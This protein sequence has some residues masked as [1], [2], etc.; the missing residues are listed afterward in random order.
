MGRHSCVMLLGLAL[1]I[2]TPFTARAE[3]ERAKSLQLYRTGR[4]QY[5]AG[6]YAEAVASF[7]AAYDAH[8]ASEYL[9]NIA[10]S[11]RKLGDCPRALAYY[12]RFRQSEP[13]DEA[14]QV[15][16]RHIE[17]LSAECGDQES[18]LAP[19]TREPAPARD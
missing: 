3:G 12:R 10:Q 13:P 18:T 4:Q 9:F 17:I 15:A 6:D 16:D 2:A 7:R 5:E 14:K 19:E 11:Y 1:A 8:P